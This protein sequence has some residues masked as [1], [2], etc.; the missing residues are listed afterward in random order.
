MLYC[1]LFV[2]I[3][4]LT[5]DSHATSVSV[6]VANDKAD[7]VLCAVSELYTLVNATFNVLKER[8]DHAVS[9]ASKTK[10]DAEHVLS[11]ARAVKHR[12]SE[13][14]NSTAVAAVEVILTKASGTLAKAKKGEELA[15][16]ARDI[17]VHALGG[18]DEVPGAQRAPNAFIILERILTSG[19]G[20]ESREAMHKHTA[21][22]MRNSSI[23]KE[24]LEFVGAAN[25]SDF[26]AW[27]KATVDLWQEITHNTNKTVT[28]FLTYVEGKD[29]Q[30]VWKE[31]VSKHLNS[32]LDQLLQY[33]QYFV[34]LPNE[35]AGR[36]NDALTEAQKELAEAEAVLGEADDELSDEDGMLKNAAGPYGDSLEK[37]PRAKIVRLLL[38]ILPIFF[39][40]LAVAVFVLLRCRRARPMKV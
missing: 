7:K 12:A 23:S 11:R 17:A 36:G 15:T 32:Y 13:D 18:S 5:A 26:S 33:T 37:G 22:C 10:T 3:F 4:A 16:K 30:H 8:A 35:V 40:V 24:K 9:H 14:H 31:H 1:T 20:H 29:A 6:D 19:G 34:A 25:F 2:L 28:D 38:I 21:S 39:V 27:R